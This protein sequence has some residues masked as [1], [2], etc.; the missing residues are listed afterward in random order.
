MIEENR[1][2]FS[3]ISFFRGARSP[4]LEKQMKNG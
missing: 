3:S 2:R 4:S 1:Y